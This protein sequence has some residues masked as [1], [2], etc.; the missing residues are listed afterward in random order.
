MS[1]VF[2]RVNLDLSSLSKIPNLHG[3]NEICQ[4]KCGRIKRT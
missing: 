4:I 2:D 3:H 1:N